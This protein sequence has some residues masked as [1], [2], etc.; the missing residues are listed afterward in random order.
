VLC[1]RG[2][3]RL[4]AGFGRLTADARLAGR[5]TP[6]FAY[7]RQIRHAEMPDLKLID[8]ESL[9]RRAP[10]HEPADHDCS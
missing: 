1:L 6:S 3:G 4:W 8:L 2:C 7:H 10:N 9:D 5:L